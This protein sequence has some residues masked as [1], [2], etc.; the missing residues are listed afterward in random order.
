MVFSEALFLGLHSA[1]FLLSYVA[2]VLC[3][4]IHGVCVSKSSLF[5]TPV[6]L[7]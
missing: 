1:T 2:F 5:M 4:H 3:I 7:D 6:R